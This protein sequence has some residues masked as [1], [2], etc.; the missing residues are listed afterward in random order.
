MAVAYF[1]YERLKDRLKEGFNYT[2]LYKTNKY[3]I[4]R[5]FFTIS[6]Y[7]VFDHQTIDMKVYYTLNDL[8]KNIFIEGKLLE[9]LWDEVIILHEKWR[10][11]FYDEAQVIK[12]YK[13]RLE[14]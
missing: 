10:F 9:D 11:D 8:L 5:R 4:G 1:S 14:K 12:E 2:I 3:N 7:Y 13:K 6:P